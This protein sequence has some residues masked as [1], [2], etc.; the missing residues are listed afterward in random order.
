[1]TRRVRRSFETAC[2]AVSRGLALGRLVG[3]GWRTH[4][5]HESQS[6]FVL[7]VAAGLPPLYATIAFYMLESG[8]QSGSLLYGAIGAGFMGVW[9]ATLFGSGAAIQVQRWQGV[10]ELH[11]AAPAPFFVPLLALTLATATTGLYSLAATLGWSWALFGVSLSIQHPG[12]FVLAVPVAVLS[13]GALGLVLSSSFVLW[14]NANAFTNMLEYPVWLV[15]GMLVPVALLPSW[16]ENL[17]WVLAPTW[18]VRAIRAAALGGDSLR[19]IGM[20]VLLMLVY[21]AVGTLL[22]WNFE[23]LARKRATLSLA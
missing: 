13:L 8:K 6:G 12:L 23:R 9:T 3:V 19:P 5:K 2:A 17:S 20:C 7:L 18:G 21:A 11:V 1:M 15:T 4:L 16:V 14:R 22:L 10:L